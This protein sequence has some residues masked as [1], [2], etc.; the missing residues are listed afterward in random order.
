MTNF[1]V[2]FIYV[3]VSFSQRYE[4]HKDL[5][6]SSLF[7]TSGDLKYRSFLFIEHSVNQRFLNGSRC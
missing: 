5:C 1:Y 3:G 4:Q 7:I 2:S 6:S